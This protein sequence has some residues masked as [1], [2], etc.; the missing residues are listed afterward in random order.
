MSTD[1]I[2]EAGIAVGTALVTNT[3][4]YEDVLQPAAKELGKAGG[5][6]G[7]AVNVCLS[8]VAAFV[9]GY[10]KI[11]LW[12]QKT[13]TEKMDK[14]PPEQIQPPKVNIAVPIIEGLRTTGEEPVLRDLYA[15]LLASSMNKATASGVLPAFVTAISELSSDEAKIINLLNKG[16]KCPV[17]DMRLNNDDPKRGF[18]LL[19]SN[20]SDI[21]E[22]AGCEFPSMS[23]TYLGNL[24]RRM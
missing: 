3:T 11:A 17:V 20:F 22:K 12:L 4:V 21:A 5:T 18:K 6:I 15:N 10:E 2:T 7:K 1:P 23:S 8:P 9:W 14:V 13:L 24:E 19:Q 16:E